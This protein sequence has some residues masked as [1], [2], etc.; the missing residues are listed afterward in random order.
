MTTLSI[1]P[2]KRLKGILDVPG[3]KS[4]SHRAL[5]LGSLAD[6]VCEVRDFLP[7]GDCLATMGCMR[8]LGIDILEESPTSL[9]IFGKGLHGLK[10]CKEALD[11]VR[12][13]TTMRMLAGLLAGQ[14]FD[15][16]LGGDVQLLRRPMNRVA[17]PLKEMG[18]KI[19]TTDGHGPLSIHGTK[20]RGMQHT[21][22]IASAQVKSA[23]LLAGLYAQGQ[24][25][26]VSPGSSRDHTERM[27]TEMG[28]HL[29]T[30]QLS[31]CIQP[32]AS[33]SPF[34]IQIPGDLSS[35]AFIMAACVLVNESDVLIRNVGT[36]PT[37][38]GLLN[39][40][41]DMGASITLENER[42]A[43]NEPAA[44]LLVKSSSLKGSQVSGD[45]VVRMIDE[46]PLL[47]VLATQAE[48][49]TTVIDASELRVKET[50]RILTITT[51]LKK[52]GARIESLPDGFIVEGPTRLHGANLDSH[53]DHR[54]AMSL[55]VAGMVADGEVNI[56]SAECISDS[57][58]G[59]IE[60]MKGL[61]AKY[62]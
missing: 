12:S 16:V 7:G 46:F 36:N 27:L 39:V 15:T 30:D 54:L 19:T 45:T 41:K 37:R 14:E 47:A 58:P 35:A 22:P 26:V 59:F 13:G 24:T 28:V 8:S 21:L 17:Q 44:D 62:A 34:S 48:G 23:I 61:G 52:M 29:D 51:E 31:V 40:L 53:G 10:G 2:T 38:T 55:A 6:G 60:R 20:L 50:D 49:T 3:D 18:A 33:L 9:Q 5:M 42:F 11:C 1:T 43:G 25:R 32:A 57:F 4:I 56:Q